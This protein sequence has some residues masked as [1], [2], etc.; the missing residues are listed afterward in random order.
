[1][2][3]ATGEVIRSL[4]THSGAI[5]SVAFSP[6]GRRRASA[7][8]DPTVR[9]GDTAT[10]QEILTLQGHS[11][12]ARGWAF[13][14]QRRRL[15]SASADRTAEVWDATELTPQARIEYEAR[16][17]VQWLVAKPLPPDQVAAAVRRDPTITEAVRQQALAWVA[18]FGRIQARAEAA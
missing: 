12:A 1:W 13:S 15:T 3:A 18:P 14:P 16:G 4:Q 17:L 11:R 7:G 8:G 10:G 5:L 2:D 6:D 9:V